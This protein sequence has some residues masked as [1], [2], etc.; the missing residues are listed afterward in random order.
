MVAVRTAACGGG[1]GFVHRSSSSSL[2]TTTAAAFILFS[3]SSQ[4]HSSSRRSFFLALRQQQ[5]AAAAQQGGGALF[6]LV[7]G[8]GDGHLSIDYPAC[9]RRR[10]W[11]MCVNFLTSLMLVRFNHVHGLKTSLIKKRGGCAL[12][13]LRSTKGCVIFSHHRRGGGGP[14]MQLLPQ[15]LLA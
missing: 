6:F 2:T 1:D 9:T 12:L 5:I 4:Q 15:V 8:D 10:Q 13:Y 3:S 11:R 7:G 14:R